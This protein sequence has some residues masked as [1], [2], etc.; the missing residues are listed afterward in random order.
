MFYNNVTSEIYNKDGKGIL[1]IPAFFEKIYV[2]WVDR[3]KGGGLKGYH[4]ADSAIVR[5]AI[6]ANN[7]SKIG[8]LRTPEGTGL[9]E[10]YRFY[11]VIVDLENDTFSPAIMS[12]SS[13]QIK[14][15]KGWLSKAKTMTLKRK[16]GSVY[17]PSTYS[18]LWRLSSVAQQNDK[19]SWRGWKIDFERYLDLSKPFE[20]GLYEFSKQFFEFAQQG[21]VK[22]ADEPKPVSSEADA[23]F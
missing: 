13:S 7:N 15:A 22:I 23:E 8:E 1:V 16:D 21:S 5:K 4:K 3:N 2:E 11:I 18:R 6:E 12:F 9:V 20:K 14:A 10:S 19:G 17:T